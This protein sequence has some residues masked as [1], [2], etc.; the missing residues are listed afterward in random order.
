VSNGIFAGVEDGL[1]LSVE[2]DHGHFTSGEG[3]G[4]TGADLSDLAHALGSIEVA[5]ENLLLLVH[6][7]GRVSKGN[8]N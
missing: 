7:S 3:A 6:A 1:L 4:E 8:G 2:F 5:H